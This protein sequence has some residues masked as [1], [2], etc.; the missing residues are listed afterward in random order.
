[1]ASAGWSKR[2]YVICDQHS[3]GQTKSKLFFQADVSSK[4]ETNEFYFTTMK[5]QVNLF[6]F[7]FLEEIEGTKKTIT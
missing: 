2:K 1:M 6:S 4:K 3:K 7:V 5:P